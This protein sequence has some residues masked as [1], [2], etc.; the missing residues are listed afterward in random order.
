MQKIIN[1]TW[2]AGLNMKGKII[3]LLE[4]NLGAYF[5]EFWREG[6]LTQDPRSLTMNDKA[7]LKSTS[8]VFKQ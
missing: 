3:K 1:P 2:A 6:F 7:S 8:F 5:H 4:D